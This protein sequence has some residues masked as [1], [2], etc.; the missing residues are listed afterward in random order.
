M[1]GVKKKNI[2][3]MAVGWRYDIQRDAGKGMPN[4]FCV[5]KH[6]RVLILILIEAVPPW[7]PNDTPWKRFFL[8][9]KK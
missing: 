9:A 4:I 7:P 3:S 1:K 5:K 6:G 2:G 8:G